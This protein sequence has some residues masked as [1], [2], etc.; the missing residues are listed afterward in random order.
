MKRGPAGLSPRHR[1]PDVGEA[2]RSR[3]YWRRSGSAVR[4]TGSPARTRAGGLLPPVLAAGVARAALRP[5]AAVSG[6][7]AGFDGVALGTVDTFW[8]RR[9]A[10][11]EI[12]PGTRGEDQGQ[13]WKGP[14]ESLIIDHR[15]QRDL[16]PEPRTP[17]RT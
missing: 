1:L 15:A 4:R 2:E 8:S 5:P 13:G 11:P 7:L 17:P 9:R 10:R 6:I 14:R 12:G 3:S 16:S